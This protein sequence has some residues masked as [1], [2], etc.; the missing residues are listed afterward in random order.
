MAEDAWRPPRNAGLEA[1][2]A[3]WRSVAG[4]RVGQPFPI[5]VL[6]GGHLVFYA[7]EAVTRR[8]PHAMALRVLMTVG[9]ALVL[10]LMVFALSNDLFLCT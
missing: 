10:G 3:C 2:S 7:Y 4:H 5:P 6:D 1:S 9:L 8:R